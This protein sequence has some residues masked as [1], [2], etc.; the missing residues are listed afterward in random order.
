[1]KLELKQIRPRRLAGHRP[2]LLVGAGVLVVAAIALLK[3]EFVG[4]NEHAATPQVPASP[5]RN[6]IEL[7]RTQ[8]QSLVIQPVQQAHF[9]SEIFTEGRITVDEDHATPVFSPYAGR[10]KTLLVKPGDTVKI[11]QPMF[12][13]EATDMVQAQNDFIAAATALNKARSAL[14][15]ADINDKR[16]AMLYEGKAVPLKEVQN[17]RAARDAAENDVR[18]AEVALEAVRNRLRILGKSDEEIAIFQEQGKIDPATIINAPIGGT[19]VQ[20]KV[21][22]GQYV[23]GGSSDPVFVVGDLSTVWLVAY[24]RESEASRVAVGQ[25]ASFKVLTYPDRNFTATINYVAAALDPNM[26]RLP[27]RAVVQ[28]TEQALRP[29]MFATA[30]IVYHEDGAS[31]AV[32]REAIIYEGNTARVWIAVTDT[33]LELRRIKVGLVNDNLVQVTDGLRVDEKVVVH[34]GVF[35]DRAATGGDS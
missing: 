30:S 34:G 17:A 6:S 29:E 1:M 24:V 31:P 18:S 5:N 33:R 23:G 20:R 9:R 8:L 7:T 10:I 2:L 28:N 3:G 21:G 19:I 15:L 4:G 16:Q 25:T 27:V 13:V 32:P 11:G 35:I 12:A 26:R 14:N 22:P